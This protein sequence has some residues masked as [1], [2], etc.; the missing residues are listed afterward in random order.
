MIDVYI[1]PR[2][3]AG[4]APISIASDAHLRSLF[5]MFTLL[6]G[7]CSTDGEVVMA[8]LDYDRTLLAIVTFG[9]VGLQTIV[10]DPRPLVALVGTFGCPTVMLG[11]V[12][13]TA[14]DAMNARRVIG[15]A[16]AVDDI[17]LVGWIDLE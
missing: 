11:Q 7:N 16:L 6:G 5:S 1:P 13:R 8:A 4:H 14:V 17:E 2:S 10:D 15:A 12:G 9:D 3:R